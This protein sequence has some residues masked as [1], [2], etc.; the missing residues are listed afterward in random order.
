M[1]AGSWI[2]RHRAV[3]TIAALVLCVPAVL[4]VKALRGHTAV[5]ASEV[6]E[7]LSRLYEEQGRRH[8]V[9]GQTDPALVYLAEAYK[10]E[11]GR[12]HV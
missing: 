9:H 11:I 12:A 8:F 3:V 5:S 4:A 2:R 1:S 10:L 6:N 7:R